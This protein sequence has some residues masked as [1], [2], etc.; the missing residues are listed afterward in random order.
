MKRRK[1]NVTNTCIVMITC[2]KI[3]HPD[4]A[5]IITKVFFVVTKVVMCSS[6]LLPVAMVLLEGKLVRPSVAGSVETSIVEIVGVVARVE[7]EVV[8]VRFVVVVG[9]AV[10]VAVIVVVRVAVVVGVIVVV[11]VA[12]VGFYGVASKVIV[13]VRAVEVDRVFVV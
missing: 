13:V 10:V 1:K 12:V 7:V 9:I 4:I 5:C 6:S 2:L 3:P 8:I 11:E